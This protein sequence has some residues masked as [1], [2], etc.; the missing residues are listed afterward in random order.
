[1]DKQDLALVN[2]YAGCFGNIRFSMIGLEAFLA[3]RDAIKS[4]DRNVP[5]ERVDNLRKVLMLY[6]LSG[7]EDSQEQ[8][9]ARFDEHI[10]T[11]LSHIINHVI[12][13]QADREALYQAWKAG[14][15]SQAKNMPDLPDFD[16]PRYEWQWYTIS[17]RGLKYSITSYYQTAEE[18]QAAEGFGDSWRVEC[19]EGSKRLVKE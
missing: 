1:M 13:Q 19:I 6:G 2:K 10:D 15:K 14:T 17:P 16:E 9:Q 11:L 4:Q 18:A 7:I 8:M 12:P 3:E 5:I